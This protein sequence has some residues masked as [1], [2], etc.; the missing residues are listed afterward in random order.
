M[1]DEQNPTPAEETPVKPRRRSPRAKTV[2]AEEGVSAPVSEVGS[3]EAPVAA[4]GPAE[5][6]ELAEVRKPTRRRKPAAAPVPEE[7]PVVQDAVSVATPAQPAQ[8]AQPAEAA[9]Q[10]VDTPESSPMAAQDDGAPSLVLQADQA[11]AALEARLAELFAEGDAAP[12]EAGEPGSA[13]HDRAGQASPGS[14]GGC[15][16]AAKGAG[17]VGHWL[18]ARY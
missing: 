13:H 3:S 15:A 18:Q 16:Q 10:S 8:P 12:T 5:V 11:A 9:E 2:A 14:R 7:T 4:D 1:S 17:P 6:A